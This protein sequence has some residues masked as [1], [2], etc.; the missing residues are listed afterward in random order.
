MA[1]VTRDAR[2]GSVKREVEPEIEYSSLVSRVVVVLVSRKGGWVVD[3][4]WWWL[5]IPLVFGE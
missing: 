1:T 3:G 2:L 4:R 5:S